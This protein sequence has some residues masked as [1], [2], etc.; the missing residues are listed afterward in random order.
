[1]G[2]VSR[3]ATSGWQHRVQRTEGR[4]CMKNR[5]SVLVIVLALLAQACSAPAAAPAATSAPAAPAATT[6]PAAKAPTTAAA[7]PTTAAAAPTTAAAAATLAPAV[8][9]P[10]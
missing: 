7:A 2:A 4:E 10:T 8:K 3:A 1:L 5:P 9:A 6:A